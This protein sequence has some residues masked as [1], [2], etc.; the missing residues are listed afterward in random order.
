MIR[1]LLADDHPL[2]REGVKQIL[3]ETSDI[4][5]ADEASDGREVLVKLGQAQYDVILLD[6]AM[7]GDSGVEVL[8]HIKSIMPDQAVLILSMYSEK[9]YALRVLR[10][11]ASGYLTKDSTPDR[12]VTA[13]RKVGAG[14]KY[15]SPELGEELALRVGTEFKVPRHERLS[16]REHQVLVMITSGKTTGE[17]ADRLSLSA[18]TISTYR[19]RL[20]EKMNMKTDAELTHYAIQYELVKEGI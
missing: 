5:V 2:F 17:I 16:D 3:A 13:I 6:I 11:G 4:V 9:Q 7:P 8:K 20:L 18:K 12:L 19:A 10:S 14:G 1:V 15:I